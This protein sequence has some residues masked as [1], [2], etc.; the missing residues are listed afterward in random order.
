MAIRLLTIGK[1]I[2]QSGQGPMEWIGGD[3][4]VV[5]VGDQIDRCRP[6]SVDGKLCHEPGATI[7]D[8]GSDLKILRLFDDLQRI[9][10]E[11]GGMVISLLGNHELMNVVGNLDYVSVEGC[12]EF[13]HFDS[14][15]PRD[16]GIHF[17]NGREVRRHVFQPGKPLARMLGCSRLSAVI[18]GSNLFVHAGMLNILLE[19]LAIKTPQDLESINILV[20][21]WL[22]GLI[23]KEYVAHIVN[24]DSTSMFWTRILG[25]IPPGMSNEDPACVSLID[26]VLTLF[27]V[28]SIVVGHTPQSFLANHSI[29]ST[30]DGSIWRVDNGSSSAFHGFD[31]VYT[32][33]NKTRVNPY[34]EPQVLEILNDTVFTTLT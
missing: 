12:R 18:V 19:K 23:N 8:E 10:S 30:C 16:K 4:C 29:N 24:A 3:T 31:T 20:K 7:D 32:G 25:K 26:R 33:S 14:L 15:D 17:K 27:R 2:R 6:R 34:R 9:A 22:L 13:E 21:K 28:G 5:Q 1:V 11:K